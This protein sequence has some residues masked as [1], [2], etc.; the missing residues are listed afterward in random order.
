M[1]A[2]TKKAAPR[3]KKTAARPKKRFGWR[4]ALAAAAMAALGVGVM[5]L[6]ASIVHIRYADVHLEDLPPSFDGTTILFAS[7]IDLCGLNTARDAA[8]LFDRLQALK[9][10]LLLLGG[11]YAS[12]SILERLNGGGGANEVAARKT[13]FDGLA[14][15]HAP[16]GKFAVSGDNDGEV[17]ALKLCMV[18]SGVELIDGGIRSISNGSDEIFIAGVG[19]GSSVIELSS[20]V[21]R[22]D[23]A[24]ALM[25]RPARVVDVRICEA[26]D[27]GQWADLSLAGHTHGGQ[28][29]IA[30]R[31]ILSLSEVEKRCIGGWSTDGGALLVSEGVGCESVNL[32]LGSHAEVHM[33]TLKCK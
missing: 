3:R 23:C 12:P 26:R 25:H 8:Q 21:S 27:G 9:P 14:D 24:I 15:F 13:F 17:G 5:H 22:G 31:P 30:G 6:N 2:R 10:D 16:M 33:I 4:I 1:A 20:A 28:I 18:G 32:R 7:D 19:E 11:D 29:R